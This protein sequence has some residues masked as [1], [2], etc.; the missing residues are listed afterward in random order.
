MQRCQV[1]GRYIAVN[2]NIAIFLFAV[3]IRINLYGCILRIDIA[4][5]IYIAAGQS[6]QHSTGARR[7]IARKLQM[8]FALQDCI[9]GGFHIA[10]VHGS[11]IPQEAVDAPDFGFI[12]DQCD[13][14]PAVE[15][16]QR[17]I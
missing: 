9:A 13:L 6:L 11:L 10:H 4:G 16:A 15:D 1:P 14:R 5:N 8:A 2:H 12:S 3:L 7:K 17:S